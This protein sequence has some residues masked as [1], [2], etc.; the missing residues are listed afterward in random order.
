MH[1]ADADALLGCVLASVQGMQA[2][3][4]TFNMPTCPKVGVCV[5]AVLQGM[6]Q[7]MSWRLWTHAT[8][9]R[10]AFRD[11]LLAGQMC[12]SRAILLKV[13]LVVL[14]PIQYRQEFSFCLVQY[15]W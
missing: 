9:S 7:G 10:R 13:V 15:T 4:Q 11:Q 5:L 3:R 6:Q 8:E 14:Q 1:E 12:H 2:L